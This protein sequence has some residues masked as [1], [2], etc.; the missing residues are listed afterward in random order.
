MDKEDWTIPKSNP[1]IESDRPFTKQEE[2]RA[3]SS[4]A[5]AKAGGGDDIPL[6]L[7]AELPGNADDEF[8]RIL[9]LSWML[10]ILP[11]GWKESLLIPVANQ[12]L[13]VFRP[14]SL[15]NAF[16]RWVDCHAPT[17][18]LAIGI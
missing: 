13:G 6:V 14:I 18:T 2:L 9:N 3:K 11:S 10:G 15:T 4:M 12:K 1:Q 17:H 16:G 8:V 5:L 7:P